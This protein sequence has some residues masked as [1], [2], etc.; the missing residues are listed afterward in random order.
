MVQMVRL[1]L[2]KPRPQ[3]A[4]L[5]LLRVPL[6]PRVPSLVLVPRLQLLQLLVIP[7]L[8]LLIVQPLRD[9]ASVLL[10]S[11]PCEGNDILFLI[12][13]HCEQWKAHC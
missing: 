10:E 9:C 13:H 4:M 1:L 8:L 5:L 6:L 7:L 11:N 12:S 2:P 3:V